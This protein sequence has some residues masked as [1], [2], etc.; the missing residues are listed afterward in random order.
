MHISHR[1]SPLPS[2]A[3]SHHHHHH[4]HHI[5][6]LNNHRSRQKHSSYLGHQPP[7]HHPN[8]WCWERAALVDG[9]GATNGLRFVTVGNA[10][11]QTEECGD[12]SLRQNVNFR[13][14]TNFVASQSSYCELVGEFFN[15]VLC[16]FCCRLMASCQMSSDNRDSWWS[17]LAIVN[18]DVSLETFIALGYFFQTVLLSWSLCAIGRWMLI[19]RTMH[20]QLSQHL[21]PWLPR[22]MGFRL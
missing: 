7:N 4:H 22:T 3:N 2:L 19:W 16:A 14:N 5:A 21:Q 15:F 17:V 10:N 13:P 11:G 18:S 20:K 12:N 9:N 1:L 6:T 8:S